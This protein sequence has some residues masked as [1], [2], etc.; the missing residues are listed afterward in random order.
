MQL[1]LSVHDH[2]TLLTVS[3]NVEAEDVS[4]LRGTLLDAI[5]EGGTDVLLD[6]RAAGPVDEL[7]L[8]ALTAARARAKHLRRRIVVIDAAEGATSC[9]LRR[10]GLQFR[11]PIYGDPADATA[12]LR[13]DRAAR[14]RLA[15]GLAP[16][17][18]PGTADGAADGAA[19]G[20]APGR[21]TGS[22][23]G[24]AL[25]TTTTEN[26]PSAAIRAARASAREAERP[27]VQP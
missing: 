14:A 4:Q 11:I 15:A 20:S 2:E 16:E 22:G 10:T 9:D 26:R 19:A 18:A 5:D 23:S 13:A 24:R 27:P 7:L 12:G 21:D 8:P 17:D 6:M 3:G 25:W 1:S